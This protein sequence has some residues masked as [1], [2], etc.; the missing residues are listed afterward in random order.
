MSSSGEEDLI[1]VPCS[2]KYRETVSFRR[3][4]AKM[5]QKVCVLS[6]YPK[7]IRVAVRDM[8][9]G[10]RIKYLWVTVNSVLLQNGHNGRRLPSINAGSH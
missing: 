7:P 5:E 10:L 8:R 6:K 1:F 9:M 4:G 2:E 3:I